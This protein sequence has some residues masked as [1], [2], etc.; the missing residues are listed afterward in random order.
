MI[1]KETSLSQ[2]FTGFNLPENL[3]AQ[4]VREQ[5]LALRRIHN[6]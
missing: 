2:S 1:L 6:F 4:L 3:I 5:S